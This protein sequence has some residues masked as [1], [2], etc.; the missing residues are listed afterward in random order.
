MVFVSGCHGNPKSE[1]ALQDRRPSC[2]ASSRICLTWYWYWIEVADRVRQLALPGAKLQGL[3]GSDGFGYIV[4]EHRCRCHEAHQQV[5]LTGQVQTV[6]AVDI[7]G[8]WWVCRFA[9]MMGI[10]ESHR[11]MAICTDITQ[12]RKVEL[13]L[14]ERE[15][16]YRELLAA[17]TNY[18]YSVKL[19]NGVPV[20]TDHSWAALVPDIR[21]GWVRSLFVDYHGSSRRPEHGAAICGGNH[22]RATKYRP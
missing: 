4:P 3:L 1:E 9:P 14:G 20:S 13:A 10:G 11:V 8:N 5:V 16:R 2:G 18:T 6:E 12:H 17:V 15:R 21:G 7:Y 22:S 19:E